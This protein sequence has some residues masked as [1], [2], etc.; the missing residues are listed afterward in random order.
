[1]VS[2]ILSLLLAFQ[3]PVISIN[4]LISESHDFDKKTI[5]IEAEVILEVLER[6]DHAWINVNDGTNAIGVYL[7]IEM[8]EEIK[9]FGD[10][11]HRG[12]IVSITGV[13]SR[14]C[15]EHGGEIDI[16]A[17]S[18]NIVERGFVV[19]HEIPMWKWAVTMF[20]VAFSSLL[21]ISHRR[22]KGKLTKREADESFD[23]K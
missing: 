5:M 3:S 23:M 19:K 16:H 7:P 15:D 4:D 18:V 8:T 22:R 20:G 9:V 2:T 11:D 17:T 12:D 10:Y 21:L 13:F 1:M 14:N 6:G